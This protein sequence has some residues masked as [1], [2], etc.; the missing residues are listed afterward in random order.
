MRAPGR[1]SRDWADAG[2]SPPAPGLVLGEA[3][4]CVGEEELVQDDPGEVERG[5][6][7]TLRGAFRLVLRGAVVGH[8]CHLTWEARSRDTASR[9]I[10]S[11][12]RTVPNCRGAAEAFRQHSVGEDSDSRGTQAP[13]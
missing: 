1:V 3:C 7:C 12:A 9:S 13:A 2:F 6:V 5:E 10:G 4:Q 8:A 11:G